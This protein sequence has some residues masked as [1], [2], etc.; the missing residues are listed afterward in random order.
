[1]PVTGGIINVPAKM[2]GNGQTIYIEKDSIY[3]KQ[4][5]AT[6]SL[7]IMDSGITFR[8]VENGWESKDKHGVTVWPPNTKCTI[9]NGSVV[10]L[11]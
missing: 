1:M 4:L 7:N 2:I 10:G 3:V 8:K 9:I 6:E 11:E 5:T